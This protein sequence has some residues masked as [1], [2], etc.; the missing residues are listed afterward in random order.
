MKLRSKYDSNPV[1][2]RNII[3]CTVPTITDYFASELKK[4]KLNIDFNLFLS[5]RLTEPV[6]GFSV[7]IFKIRV[8]LAPFVSLFRSPNRL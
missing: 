7:E 2:S 8:P 1:L 4:Q 5:Q 3:L 6:P